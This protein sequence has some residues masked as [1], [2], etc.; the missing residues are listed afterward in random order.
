V[1]DAPELVDSSQLDYMIK[2]SEKS[3]KVINVLFYNDYF[4]IPNWGMG[5]N[6]LGAPYF[7]SLNCPVTNCIFSHDPNHLPQMTDYDA[8]VFHIYQAFDADHF[9]WPIKRKSDQLYVMAIQE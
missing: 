9:S 5:N 6:I 8:I 7:Q 4:G 2:K 3:D 1:S